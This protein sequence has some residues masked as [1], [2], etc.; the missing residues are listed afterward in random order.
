MQLQAL[1]ALLVHSVELTAPLVPVEELAVPLVL[2]QELAELEVT[3]ALIVLVVFQ[4]HF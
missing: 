3:Q 1:A 4:V 2:A